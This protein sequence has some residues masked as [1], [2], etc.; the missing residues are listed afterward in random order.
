MRKRFR[1]EKIWSHLRPN[2]G[3]MAGNPRSSARS[4]QHCTRKELAG[5]G[6]SARDWCPLGGGREGRAR[7]K[8]I[9]GSI[10]AKAEFEYLYD[11]PYTD[12]SRLRVAGPFTVESL[13][14]HGV[15][16][17][18]ADDSLGQE[19]AEPGGAGRISDKWSSKT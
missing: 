17:G 12:A 3:K 11:K 19:I 7:Q 10:A 8:E 9:N 6:N 5:M 4:A 18:D 2:T 16:P 14:P 13:S 1:I 15:V